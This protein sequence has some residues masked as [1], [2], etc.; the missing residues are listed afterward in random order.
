MRD[1]LYTPHNGI[2]HLRRFLRVLLETLMELLFGYVES[3]GKGVLDSPGA[4]LE[5]ACLDD[6]VA[7]YKFLPEGLFKGFVLMGEDNVEDTHNET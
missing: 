2:G 6:I 1:G 3:L 4:Y 7:V 5:I